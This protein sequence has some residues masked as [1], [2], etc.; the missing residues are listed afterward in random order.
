MNSNK[1]FKNLKPLI[2]LTVICVIVA[3]LLGVTNYITA[4]IIERVEKEKIA[5]SLVKAFPGGSFADPET[6]PEG[7]PETVGA[8]YKDKNGNGHVVTLTTTKGFTG[9]P[10]NLSVGVGVDGVIK[11]VVITGYND[12]LG[13]SSVSEAVSGFTG[14]GVDGVEDVELVAGVTYSSNAVRGAVKDALAVLGFGGDEGYTEEQIRDMA[15]ALIGSDNLTEIANPGT[16][17][18][19]KKIYKEGGGKGFVVYTQMPGQYVPVASEGLVAIDPEGK[20]IGVDL[21]TWVVGHGVEPG[22]FE[23][24][25]AG[26]TAA[27]VGS[28]ELVTGATYTAMDF[29]QSV[30]DALAVVSGADASVEAPVYSIIAVC[31]ISAVIGALIAYKVAVIIKR[32]NKA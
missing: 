13:K 19:V 6:L 1:L 14:V 15:A 18:S 7:A 4:P 17:S 29:R 24:R 10:I 23:T 25:F 16:Y 28:V 20:I 26:K 5:E 31:F 27:D 2:V 22:D 11:G 9:Q 32:R 3:A 21:I 30:A 8:I 12:S